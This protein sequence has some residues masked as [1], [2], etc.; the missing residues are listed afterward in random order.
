MKNPESYFK[1]EKSRALMTTDQVAFFSE[2]ETNESADDKIRKVQDEVRLV[3]KRFFSSI[4]V[5]LI[6]ITLNGGLLSLVNNE[7]VHTL[8]SASSSGLV[9]L[10]IQ[11]FMT[12]MMIISH[13]DL[14]IKILIKFLI[15]FFLGWFTTMEV[16]GYYSLHFTEF[17]SACK[18]PLMWGSESSI[19]WVFLITMIGGAMYY[20]FHGNQGYK[21]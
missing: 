17:S 10:G 11:I 15:V 18:P 16:L 20:C 9:L 8:I 2:E 21:K 1:E 14:S 12:T 13:I 4:E 7:C 5:V 6:L 3:W 19:G